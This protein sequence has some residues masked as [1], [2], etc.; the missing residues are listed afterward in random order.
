MCAQ[1]CMQRPAVSAC[2]SA[3]ELLLSQMFSRHVLKN[4]CP[5]SHIGVPPVLV[6][7]CAAVERCTLHALPVS[8]DSESTASLAEIWA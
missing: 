6:L 1:P 8:R 5:Y 3:R 4:S 2:A 7:C